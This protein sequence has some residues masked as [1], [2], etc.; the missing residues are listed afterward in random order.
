M[1]I[2][3][4]VYDAAPDPAAPANRRVAVTM[5]LFNQKGLKA[6]ESAAVTATGQVSTRPNATPVQLQVPLKTVPPGNYV[7]QLNVVD[8]AGRKFAFQRANLVIQ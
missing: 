1:Y 2:A 4:D 3:F 5:S 8:E 7:C 6:F